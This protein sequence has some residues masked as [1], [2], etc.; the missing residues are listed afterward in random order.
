MV[1]ALTDE[2]VPPDFRKQ[3]VRTLFETMVAGESLSVVGIGST[4][5]S[6]LLRLLVRQDV[7]A[8]HLGPHDNLMIIYLN[9]HRLI[10]L[11][12]NPLEQVGASWAGYEL[13]LDGMRRAIWELDDQGRLPQGSDEGRGLVSTIKK[14]YTAMYSSNTLQAQAGIRHLESAVLDVLLNLGK[15][16][17]IVFLFDEMDEF[18]ERLPVEF[19]QGLRSVRDEFKQRLMYVTTS[20]LPLSELVEQFA[21]KHNQSHFEASMEGLVELFHEKVHYIYPLDE[22]SA[23]YSVGRLCRRHCVNLSLSDQARLATQLCEVTGGHVG[24]MRRGFRRA[25]KVVSNGAALTP[26]HLLGDPGVW[27]ECETILDSL[28]VPEQIILPQ[29][30]HKI[31]LKVEMANIRASL[32]RKHLIDVQA[33]SAVVRI[34]VLARFIEK[35]YPI[36]SVGL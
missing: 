2:Q 15:K 17:K 23:E 5:K 22:K 26:D 30:A 7:Q 8:E 1:L 9:S 18:F 33:N 16:W 14:Y 19:F 13:M 24:L 12:G 29:I 31:Q 10:S 6:N 20:R 27:R 35:E 11:Q 36:D 32:R 3:E 25:A 34:P 4:G 28:P 21:K